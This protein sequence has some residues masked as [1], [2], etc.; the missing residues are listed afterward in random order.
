MSWSGGGAYPRQPQPQQVV[1]PNAGDLGPLVLR[2]ITTFARRNKI[3][4]GG[5]VLGIL[6]LLLIGS[7]TKL[8]MDQARRYDKIMS[9]IDVEAEYQASQQYWLAQQAYHA[10]KG[11]FTCDH[12]CQRNKARMD[13]KKRMLDEIRAEG[14]ARMSDA[15]SVAGLWSEVGVGEV[16]ESFW[17][18]FT[19][20][21]QF[22]KRQSMWDAMFIG[23]R[24][25]TRDESMW[26]Y[27]LRVL[28]QVLIN[29]TM[30]LVVALVFFVFGL[31]SIIRS[32]QPNPLVAV[33]FFICAACAACSFVLT[34]V[35]LIYGAAAGGVYSLVKLG[36]SGA[37]A[38]LQQP[39][40]G[41]YVYN[42]PHYQ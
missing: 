38:R 9:T 4:S 41:E 39:R 8:T 31:W 28:M 40:R 36:E 23:I 18:Y 35:L 26:E 20:G 11:W 33:V 32:Y 37:R 6:V 13:E 22:A 34:Y 42:R 29:F 1:L 25:M 12:L 24:S 14:Y 7:G 15:K 5:Y 21:H 19:S 17:K 16:K 3:I 2:G 30:G 10:T 27:A